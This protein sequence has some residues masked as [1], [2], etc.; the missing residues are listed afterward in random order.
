MPNETFDEWDG[1]FQ[2]YFLVQG[3][4]APSCDICGCQ[5]TH[6]S[7]F[8][9]TPLCGIDLNSIPKPSRIV[10]FEAVTL[11]PCGIYHTYIVTLTPE[12]PA[13][14]EKPD[15]NDYQGPSNLPHRSK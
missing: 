12:G 6:F 8:I 1:R 15:K 13:F 7:G 14:A 4:A 3:E 5:V 9:P 2:S 10:E 11:C